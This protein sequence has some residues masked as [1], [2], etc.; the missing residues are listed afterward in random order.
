MRRAA[1]MQSSHLSALPENAPVVALPFGDDVDETQRVEMGF[2]PS[3]AVGSQ[4]Q[5]ADMSE[6]WEIAFDEIDFLP[7]GTPCS[8]NRIGHGGFGEVFLGQLG[9][10]N[11][12]VKRLFNQE[13]A[14]QGMREFRAEVSILSRLRHPSI[15]LWLG[16]STTAPNCTIVL[17]Y[18]DRGSL[19]QLLHRSD[20]PYTLVTAVKWCI[21][22]ARGMLYLHQHKPFPII[23]CDLNSNN[24]L[25]NREWVVKITDFGLSKV[26]RTSRL[27]RRSGII[28]TVN[29]AAPEVIRGAPSSE[30][31][32]VYAFGV[33]AWEILTRK[34][35]WK[36]L[37][38]YQIIYKMTAAT[39]RQNA[40]GENATTENFQ[41][42][43]TFP[44]GAQKMLHACWLSN[45]TDRP[46]FP[47]LVEECRE[48]LRDENAKAKQ[49]RDD[50]KR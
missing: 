28:G 11:V 26:K 36:D 5:E 41:V 13:H 46:F 7:S 23:H 49:T 31:S 50:A 35:P 12:A 37:T 22:V 30:S 33:L 39:R 24:V 47:K 48:M 8:E 14:E 27:S 21:S 3:S 2:V 19:S 32:D 38:E 34:I 6:E 43:E 40:T 20:T 42:D 1:A 16:A 18:M 17:E 15:V 10:M 45:P 25:V 9:G 44:K 4:S 29:Y